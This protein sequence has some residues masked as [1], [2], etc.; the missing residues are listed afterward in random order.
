[1]CSPRLGKLTAMGLVNQFYVLLCVFLTTVF[2][3]VVCS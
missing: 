1:M 2:I 3:C